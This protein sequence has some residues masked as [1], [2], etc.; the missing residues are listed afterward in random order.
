LREDLRYLVS[1]QRID[2]E[3]AGTNIRKKDLPIKISTLGEAFRLL[4][5]KVDEERHHLNE[6]IQVHRA[7]EEGL[8]KGVENL[9]KTKDRL[10]EVKTN[11]EYQAMLKEIE[12]FVKKNSEIE[13]EIITKLE[14]IDTAKGILKT[15]ESEL[16]DFRTTYEH[17]KNEIEKELGLIGSEISHLMNDR[18][19]IRGKINSEILKK[20]DTIKNRS[21]GSAVVSV[22]KGVCE[23]CHMNIPPQMYN[24]LQKSEDFM[25]CPFCSRIIYWDDKGKNG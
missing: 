14:E 13:D 25:Q 15:K 6:I 12:G 11:K 17:D 7:K 18:E 3:L 2:A 1:L 5:E 4:N 19:E 8:K 21:N 16:A 22:W 9:K 20:Y 23:G 24:E 10:L